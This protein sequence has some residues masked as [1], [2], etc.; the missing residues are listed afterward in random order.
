[1][2]RQLAQVHGRQEFRN[3]RKVWITAEF[4]GKYS[5]NPEFPAN[6]CVQFLCDE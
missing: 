2:V 3:A 5:F 1:M 4:D 6:E